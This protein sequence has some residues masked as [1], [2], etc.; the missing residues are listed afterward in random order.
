V[1]AAIIRPIYLFVMLNGLVVCI[2][3]IC[4]FLCKL[5][6][7]QSLLSLSFTPESIFVIVVDALMDNAQLH[8]MNRITA[9]RSSVST[10]TCCIHLSALKYVELANVCLTNRNAFALNE[11]EEADGIFI[12]R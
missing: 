12:D 4:C 3:G 2:K 11:L 6:I 10:H 9:I 5:C 8:I 7:M 1:W